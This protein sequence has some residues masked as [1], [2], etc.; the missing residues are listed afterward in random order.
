MNPAP[1][2]P[3]SSV[4]P[5]ERGLA[6]TVIALIAIAFVTL[7]FV[8][9][10][11]KVGAWLLGDSYEARAFDSAEWK[12]H[13]TPPNEVENPERRAMAGDLLERGLLLGLGGEGVRD[14]LGPADS[15]RALASG[16]RIWIYW[17]D[18]GLVDP[19]GLDVVFDA[20]GR[21]EK[22]VALEH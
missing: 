5:R 7:K 12:A 20:A 16:E 10:A 1:D 4:S 8:L 2:P 6:I 18:H 17:L 21:V 19:Y 3:P 14:L 15:E 13:P 11:L 22:A 9:P